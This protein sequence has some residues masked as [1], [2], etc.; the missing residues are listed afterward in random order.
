[1]WSKQ[2][3]RGGIKKETDLVGGSFLQDTPRFN[4]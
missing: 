4:T 2:S 3:L 1:M